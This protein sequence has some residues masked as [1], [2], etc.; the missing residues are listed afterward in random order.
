MFSKIQHQFVYNNF[1]ELKKTQLAIETTPM[2]LV[3]KYFHQL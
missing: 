2:N 1:N 3:V